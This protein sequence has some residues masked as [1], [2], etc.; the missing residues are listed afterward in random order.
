V[1]DEAFKAA[2]GHLLAVPL[3]TAVSGKAAEIVTPLAY[4]LAVLNDEGAEPRR[5]DDI[6]KAAAPYVHA[7]KAEDSKPTKLEVVLT[8]KRDP[9]AFSGRVVNMPELSA[10]VPRQIAIEQ[11]Q[12]SGPEPTRSE[13][14]AAIL[15]SH[16]GEIRKHLELVLEGV[17]D[18]EL[19]SVYE[20]SID[21]ILAAANRG[22][23]EQAPRSLLEQH[24]PAV[25]QQ[26]GE[27][28][29]S[30][31]SEAA[32]GYSTN[33]DVEEEEKREQ[34]QDALERVAAHNATVRA[35][36]KAG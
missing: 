20:R 12:Q 15:G 25:M 8:F 21:T 22:D 29:V 32:Q 3:E 7:R 27:D 5:R 10:P 34:L 33:L 4:M 23:N 17:P 2:A 31:V 16:T 28:I 14:M 26:T 35:R 30:D 19:Q 1:R 6:A 13:L 11:V 9:N 18:A 36:A 24:A